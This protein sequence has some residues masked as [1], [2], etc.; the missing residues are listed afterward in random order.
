MSKKDILQLKVMK[1]LWCRSTYWQGSCKGKQLNRFWTWFSA[2]YC[3]QYFVFTYWWNCTAAIIP[4]VHWYRNKMWQWFV[5]TSINL[6][7]LVGGSENHEAMNRIARLDKEIN[8]LVRKWKQALWGKAIYALLGVAELN[9]VTIIA[10]FGNVERFSNP[11][12]LMAYFGL[13]PFI[14]STVKKYKI[15][16]DDGNGEWIYSQSSCGSELVVLAASSYN[17]TE[18]TIHNTGHFLEGTA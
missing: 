18:V 13:V 14:N 15:W 2:T 3:S 6:L 8:I 10:E 12:Q 11:K 17:K 5:R 9:S 7:P 4:H 16:R 1:I